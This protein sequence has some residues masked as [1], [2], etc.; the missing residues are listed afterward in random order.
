MKI[1]ACLFIMATGLSSCV[2]VYYS[3]NTANAPLLSEKGESRV[4]ALY[5][6]GSNSEFAGGELQLAYA[7]TDHVGMMVNG[8]SASKKENLYNWDIN[9]NSST[10]HEEKGNGSYLEAAAGYFK[11]VD[12][13]KNRWIMEIYGGLGKGIVNNDYGYHDFSKVGITKVF[14][15]PSIGYRSG[16][17]ELAFVPKIS[18]VKW[19]IKENSIV[20]AFNDTPRGDMELIHSK[21]SFVAFEPSVVFRGGAKGFKV[22]AALSFSNYRPYSAFYSQE[23]TESLNASL[24]ISINIKPG[25]KNTK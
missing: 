4:N 23:L 14:V 11:N 15:Q 17:I 20:Y 5:C 2:H 1:L 25:K 24:G 7:L 3:P 9:S 16:R 8:F 6:S 13:R 18:F 12:K 10:S 21:P 19:R 22:Q